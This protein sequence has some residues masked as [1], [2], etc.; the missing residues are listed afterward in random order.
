MAASSPVKNNRVQ[1][2]F[3]VRAAGAS[4][5]IHCGMEAFAAIKFSEPSALLQE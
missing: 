5:N 1:K 4:G 3:A 2:T